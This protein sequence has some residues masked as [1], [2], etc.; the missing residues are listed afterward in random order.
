MHKKVFLV[1]LVLI[2]YNFFFFNSRFELGAFVF[3]LLLAG[4]LIMTRPKIN[5]TALFFLIT[6]LSFS[7]QYSLTT[8]PFIKLL[9]GFFSLSSF[10]LA[11]FF[12]L[13]PAL[14]LGIINLTLSPLVLVKE[15]LI[16][17]F[18]LSVKKQNKKSQAGSIIKI[19]LLSLI[20]S[21]PVLLVLLLLFQ[22]ADPIFSFYTR[23][24]I[25]NILKIINRAFTKEFLPRLSESLI[26]FLFLLT[27]I[28]LS[29]NK[30]NN[31]KDNFFEPSKLIFKE[32]VF[33]LSSTFLLLAS[34]IFIQFKYLFYLIPERQLIRFGIN[35][36]SEYVRKG[37]L[38][39]IIACVII[40]TIVFF[41]TKIKQYLTI[42]A[43]KIMTIL[44]L[45]LTLEIFLLILSNFKRVYLYAA[46]HGLTEVRIFGLIFLFYLSLMLLFLILR[47]LMR[48]KRKMIIWLEVL[49][50][51]FILMATNLINVDRLIA[52][53]FPPTVNG[54]LDTVYLADLSADAV[55]GWLKAVAES[56]RILNLIKREKKI[57]KEGNRQLFYL[58]LTLEALKERIDFLKSNYND[59]KV[60]WADLNFSERKAWKYITN[61]PEFKEIDSMLKKIEDLE[62]TVDEKTKEETDYDRCLS[63]PLL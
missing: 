29:V 19:I 17:L 53:Y 54:E 36:Y 47:N 42:K 16:S 52:N 61:H 1:F 50:T 2:L 32:I 48:Q 35:T 8:N 28:K 38:E 21:L 31:L 34:F 24:I 45:G 62:K 37:F 4:F 14:Q 30:I 22:S 18:S 7:S 15:Y 49:T 12:S 13:S 44:N 60:Y 51:V 41:T 43:A 59:K 9:D 63:Y 25:E 20:I 40:Y 11:I 55:S 3:N 39:L 57:D 26:L 5:R 23:R 27:T 10:F 6:S 46:S 56:Q 33:L 58:R